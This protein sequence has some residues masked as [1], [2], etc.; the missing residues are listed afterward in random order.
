VHNPDY[1]VAGLQHQSLSFPLPNFLLTGCPA[2]KKLLRKIKD[3]T[4]TL[5]GVLLPP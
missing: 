4:T 1:A 5:P 3:F 2:N